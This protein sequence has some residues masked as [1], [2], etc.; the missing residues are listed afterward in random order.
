MKLIETNPNGGYRFFSEDVRFMNEISKE[1]VDMV[2][3]PLT[4]IHNVII[5]GG[6]TITTSGLNTTISEGVVLFNGELMRFDSQTYVTPTGADNAY[7]VLE[8]NVLETRLFQAGNT[9]DVYQENV[10]KVEVGSAIPANSI[11][12]V[13]TKRYWEVVNDQIVHPPAPSAFEAFYFATFVEFTS[14]LIFLSADPSGLSVSFG[15]NKQCYI[16]LNETNTST[17]MKLSSF[18]SMAPLGTIIHIR[19]NV[20]PDNFNNPFQ[21]VLNSTVVGG[22]PPITLAGNPSANAVF[23]PIPVG[24]LIKFIRTNNGWEI[25]EY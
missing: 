25:M 9:V 18:G 12:V 7:W 4:A 2:I 24:T 3:K 11:N 14:N 15:V 21:I 16:E 5:L 22:L 10:A 20:A 8:N 13:S 17:E 6:C 19:F 1:M 23:A